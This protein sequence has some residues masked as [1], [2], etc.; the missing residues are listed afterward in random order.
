MSDDAEDRAPTTAHRGPPTGSEV[1]PFPRLDGERISSDFASQALPD[2][3]ALR[4]TEEGRRVLICKEAPGVNV[5]VD[6][7][8]QLSESEVRRLG[9]R[10][11]LLDGAGQFGP[12]LDNTR[13]LYNLDHH[14]GCVRA[15]TLA[16][17]EQALVMVLK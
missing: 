17:C 14:A 15:L 12:M 5:V 8:V 13:K 9:E 10:V 6:G 11:I 2:R 7:S 4:E 1:I 3:Y 16:T